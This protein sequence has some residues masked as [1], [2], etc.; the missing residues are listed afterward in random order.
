MAL[1]AWK[2]QNKRLASAL[3]ISGRIKPEKAFQPFAI[4]F[5]VQAAE[6]LVTDTRQI[7]SVS[8]EGGK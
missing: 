5:N 8:A 2:L 3:D 7:L 6:N 1:V 4:I